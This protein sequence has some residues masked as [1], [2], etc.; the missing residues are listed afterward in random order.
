MK[1]SIAILSILLLVS[2]LSCRNDQDH[3]ENR[4]AEDHQR[5]GDEDAPS[6]I[7]CRD[8]VFTSETGNGHD[9]EPPRKDLQQWRQAP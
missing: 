6:G 4:G 5:R 2:S 7:I 8:S 1:K 9:E 3:I